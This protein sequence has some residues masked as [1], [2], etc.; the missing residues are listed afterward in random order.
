MENDMVSLKAISKIIIREICF[1]IL[2]IFLDQI[3]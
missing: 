1:W 2:Y 3:F